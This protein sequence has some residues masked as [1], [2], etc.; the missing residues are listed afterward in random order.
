MEAQ[1]FL[2]RVFRRVPTGPVSGWKFEAWNHAGKPTAEGFGVLAVP[3][4]DPEKL[5]ARVMD[6]ARYVGNVEHVIES[7]P[8]ADPRYV[9]PQK[10]RFYQR[11][12]VPLLA[13]IHMELV[14]EDGGT[15]D[16]WRVA[17]WF[18]LDEETRRLSNKDA[19]RSQYNVGAWLVKPGAVGYALSS[20]PVKDDVGMLKFAA[21]TRG[22]D[23][24]ASKVVKDNIEGMARWAARS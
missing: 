12:N 18:Q 20:A 13:K 22:A 6:V 5:I 9:P 21:L 4:V 7:R 3:G 1:D 24:A 8:I 17:S 14:L 11:I 10:V 23:A 16:G 2:D 15:R 19:A